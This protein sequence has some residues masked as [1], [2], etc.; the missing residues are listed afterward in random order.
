MAGV[1]RVRSAKMGRGAVCNVFYREFAVVFGSSR[2]ASASL[3]SVRFGGN[4]S[5]SEGVV[6]GW[7][8]VRKCV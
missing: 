2:C 6:A 5:S 8:A 3:R 1:N 4:S 7:L